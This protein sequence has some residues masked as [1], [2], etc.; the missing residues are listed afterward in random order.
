MTVDYSAT[1]ELSCDPISCRAHAHPFQLAGQV[2]CLE[3]LPR[4]GNLRWRRREIKMIY[5]P[6]HRRVGPF[7]VRAP[8][9]YTYIYTCCTERGP[10]SVNKG[11]K[12]SLVHGLIVDSSKHAQLSYTVRTYK[13]TAMIHSR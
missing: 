8:M 2:S 4:H 12:L 9:T 13:H 11:P 3:L 1:I 7:R 10:I 6:K 5:H